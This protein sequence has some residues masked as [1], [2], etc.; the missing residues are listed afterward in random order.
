MVSDDIFYTKFRDWIVGIDE[1]AEELR[2]E[3]EEEN[4]DVAGNDEENKDGGFGYVENEL[5]SHRISFLMQQLEIV[6]SDVR[7]MY[8]Q[9]MR[10]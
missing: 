1:V 8:R 5:R 6:P 7:E 9:M 2:R 4:G 3:G 10:A